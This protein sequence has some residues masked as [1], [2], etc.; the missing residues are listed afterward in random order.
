MKKSPGWMAGAFF[1]VSCPL[2]RCWTKYGENK[3]REKEGRK[4]RK[5]R[6]GLKT[7]HYSFGAEDVDVAGRAEDVV[8]N[9]IVFGEL[10]GFACENVDVEAASAEENEES[11]GIEAEFAQAVGR[12]FEA[13]RD[14]GKLFKRGGHSLA[15]HWL[16]TLHVD[17]D[18]GDAVDFVFMNEG[19]DRGDG[20][21]SDLQGVFVLLLEFG[22]DDTMVGG[23]RVVVPELEH[24]F[25]V[26]DGE[27]VRLDAIEKA[28]AAK[29]ATE[30]GEGFC[31]RFESKYFARRRQD[32][33]E[34]VGGVTDI[35]ADIE[36]V[37]RAEEFGI[38][39]REGP[40]GIFVVALV[41][42]RC[43]EKRALNRAEFEDAGFLDEIVRAEDGVG[44][45]FIAH[46]R[47]SR[48]EIQFGAWI[49]CATKAQT[50]GRV[51]KCSVREKKQQ[52]VSEWIGTRWPNGRRLACERNHCRVRRGGR[53]A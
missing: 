3:K 44:D 51:S 16:V 40:E 49:Q 12:I 14:V 8:D 10:S 5:K 46:G 30:H 27:I 11:D 17:F 26:A 15:D 53:G 52:G 24:T 39:L 22:R 43:G 7:R 23:V 25:G 34:D 33:G 41:K 38:A 13:D 1:L 32:V 45:E 31:V 2:R 28:L 4:R 35:C 18:E 19:V 47:G 21:A 36:N 42:K 29:N 9:G 37:A 20:N 6:T 48:A 50:A